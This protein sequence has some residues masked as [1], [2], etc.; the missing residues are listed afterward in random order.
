MDLTRLKLFITVSALAISLVYVPAQNQGAFAQSA[1]LVKINVIITDR[2]GHSIDGVRKEDLQLFDDGQPETISYFSQEAPVT[3]GLVIDGSGSL[4]TQFLD[5]LD[6]AKRVVA[7]NQS[8]D[9]TFI[10]KFVS[11]DN[12]RT[13][14]ELTSD[15]DVLTRALSSLKVEMGQT[16]L[17]DGL[18]LASQYAI[19]H[20][21]ADGNHRMAIVL[22]S[23]GEDRASYY[24]ES[25]LFKLLRKTDLQVF[26]IGLMGKLESQGGL[27]RK[28][29]RQAAVEFLTKL[30]K[31]TGG[32]AF[33]IAS[34]KDLAGAIDQLTQSVHTQY[35]IGYRPTN[36][37]EKVSRKVEVKVV[38]SPEHEKWI[39][40]NRQVIGLKN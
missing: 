13:I 22:I 34:Q 36:N 10:I 35:V 1:P 2:A 9:E 17:I 28:S 37:P 25:D 12:V 39:V 20:R 32:R 4:K 7:T 3:Y 31:E 38:A 23:D 14:Q 29:P 11:S 33:L 26:V 16:A 15:K 19:D 6:T 27:I 40:I 8:N 21:N 30:T 24:T 18:Y 5:I